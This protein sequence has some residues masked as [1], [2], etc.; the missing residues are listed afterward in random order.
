MNATKTFTAVQF[1][2]VAG[3]GFKKCVQEIVFSLNFF[4]EIIILENTNLKAPVRAVAS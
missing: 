4:R 2:Q 1:G 3:I